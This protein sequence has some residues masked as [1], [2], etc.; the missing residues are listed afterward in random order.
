[1]VML[2][3]VPESENVMAPVPPVTR[4]CG[5]SRA[6]PTVVKSM[7]EPVI[8]IRA[9]TVIEML[10]LSLIPRESVAVTLRL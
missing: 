9:L 2:S 1:M 10:S 7:A 5:E 4:Y 8:S 6:R 3:C